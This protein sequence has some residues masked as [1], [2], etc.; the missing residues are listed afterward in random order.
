MNIEE[1]KQA[2]K[3][4]ATA[5]FISGTLTTLVVAFAMLNDS[6]GDLAVWNDPIN[7]VD[8]TLIFAC[9]IGMLK[10][11]RTASI[12]VFIYFIVSKATITLETGQTTGL[13][14]TFIFLFF[15]AK[16]I[17]GSFAYKK[18]M[19]AED[20][21]FRSAPR[22]VYWMSVPTLCLFFVA[23]GY[24]VLSMTDAVP[25]T[26]VVEGAEISES[27]RNLM[28]E[29]GIIYDDEQ[30][31]YMYSYGVTSILEGGS[32]LSDRAVIM[33][34]TDEDDGFNVYE[35]TFDQIESVQ[36]LEQGNLWNETVY[37]VNGYDE[38][39]WIT[40]TLSAEDEGDDEF[41][42]ALK[43]QISPQASALTSN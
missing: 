34:H 7:V 4:G 43:R 1:A 32:V 2:C 28:I 35:I 16:A 10:F 21:Q 25:S 23:A 27:D 38:N 15:F 22:W 5:A 42:A 17:Q 39:N 11:S 30:I 40:V 37:Q 14:M 3:N 13:A 26:E 24:G 41:V 18:H 6:A 33:Y 29:N 9:A 19:K 31:E 20:P 36:L 12:T 8:I